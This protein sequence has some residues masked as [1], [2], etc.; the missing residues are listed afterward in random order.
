PAVGEGRADR[1]VRGILEG[2]RGSSRA[3]GGGRGSSD[4]AGGAG[5]RRGAA[6]PRA[7]APGGVGAGWRIR[8]ER[9]EIGTMFRLASLLLIVLQCILRAAPTGQVGGGGGGAVASTPV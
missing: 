4:G 6:E 5:R 8:E 1:A 3:P 7:D 9:R 2:R